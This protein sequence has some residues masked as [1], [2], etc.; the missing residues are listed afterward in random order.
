[1]SRCCL[2]RLIHG[3]VAACAVNNDEKGQGRLKVKVNQNSHLL[4]FFLGLPESADDVFVLPALLLLP[5]PADPGDVL[6]A[7]VRE[8]W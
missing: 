5:L 2:H 6:V 8:P 1:M 7:V 3:F 4:T